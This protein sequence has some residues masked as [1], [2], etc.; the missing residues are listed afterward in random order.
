MPTNQETP[1]PVDHHLDPSIAR[2]PRFDRL[3]QPVKVGASVFHRAADCPEKRRAAGKFASGG[4]AAGS[5]SLLGG[6]A[7]Q[8]KLPKTPRNC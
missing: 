2:N 8:I 3:E 1:T 7:R 4:R 6:S 5:S